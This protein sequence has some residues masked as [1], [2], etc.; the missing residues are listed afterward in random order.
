MTLTFHC[1]ES[2]EEAL[3]VLDQRE[4]AVALGGGTGI[5]ILHKQG[6]LRTAQLV[7][8][9][10]IPDL[11]HIELTPTHLRI[12][13]MV[14]IRALERHKEVAFV[15]PLLPLACHEVG[16]PRVRNAA[17]IGGNLALGDSRFDPP[18]ALLVAHAVAEVA[19]V[20]G[21]RLIPLEGFFSGSGR[22]ALERG[23]LICAIEVPRRS[24][25][26][27]T[28]YVKFRS[29]GANDRSSATVAVERAVDD[30]GRVTLRLGIGA[31]A[32]TPRLVE[33]VVNDAS[34]EDAIGAATNAAAE[35]FAPVSDIRGSASYKMI[36]GGVAVQQAVREAWE[37]ASGQ[38]PS[39]RGPLRQPRPGQ[40]SR[41]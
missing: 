26:R 1:P 19:S 3:A 27:G 14:P 15:A 23:E 37:E 38:T 21:R 24:A 4:D 39:V 9:G 18:V 36:L 30:A 12:G 17:S 6:R 25:P 5:S 31:L 20:R 41:N 33:L 40:V 8:L 11:N 2:L 7:W 35:V 10:Q 13:P 28:A 34:L 16:S 32:P 22:T 29:L